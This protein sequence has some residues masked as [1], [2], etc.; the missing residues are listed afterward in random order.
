MAILL[1]EEIPFIILDTNSNSFLRLKYK[2]LKETFKKFEKI[3]ELMRQIWAFN[4][5]NYA[6]IKNVCIYLKIKLVSGKYNAHIHINT[7]KK[8]RGE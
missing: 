8:R 1:K 2:S 3:N 5:D 4:A 6:C 7:E